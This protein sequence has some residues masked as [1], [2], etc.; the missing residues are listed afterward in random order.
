MAYDVPRLFDRVM[1][2]QMIFSHSISTPRSDEALL[3]AFADTGDQA[4]FAEIVQRHGGMVV[5]VCRSVLGTSSEA[6]D[7]SQAVFLTL[8][9][10]ASSREVRRH[11]VGWLHRVAWYVAAR[12][13]EA[14]SIR[15]RHEQEAAK[16]RPEHRPPEAPAIPLETLHAGLAALPEKY[17]VP[18]LLHHIEG[19]T[20]EE[21]AALLG[22]KVGAL[23]M[24]LHRGRQLLRAQ[25]ARKGLVETTAGVTAAL[26][27]NPAGA[28]PPAF[29]ALA[30]KTAEALFAGQ[31]GTTTL[32][33]GSTTLALSKAAMNMLCLTKAKL[34]A[35]FAAAALLAG[36]AIE[37]YAFTG[38]AV[39]AQ[40][41]SAVTPA[42]PLGAGYAGNFTARA[43][44]A[45]NLKVIG[46]ALASFAKERD[47][48]LPDDLGELYYV[49]GLPLDSFVNP[50]SGTVVPGDLALE[51]RAKWVFWN[52]DYE[53]VS[54]LK[55]AGADAVIAYEKNAGPTLE[56]IY[57]L[58]RD[59]HVEYM[60]LDHA[61]QA[62]D[63]SQRVAAPRAPLG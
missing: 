39:P 10:K 60:A 38:P 28:V 56:G 22:C 54:G 5:A 41:A 9:Q 55:N 53:Y 15:R 58:F 61:R 32:V 24:R 7:A 21:T 62:I 16:M 8:A 42:A 17:R 48:A 25:L 26:T 23:A 34:V 36:G 13:A 29:V 37:K 3:A 1:M 50:A 44:S 40:P 47:G 33:A 49:T 52:S 2:V 51:I 59:G 27:L 43:Q 57:V 63:Q 11:V 31:L 20:Q 35:G 4:A 19:R 45:A 12:A 30:A 46:E 14:R 18:L 6:D